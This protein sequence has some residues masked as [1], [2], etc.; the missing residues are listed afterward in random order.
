M[1]MPMWPSPLQTMKMTIVI[2]TGTV[3]LSEKNADVVFCQ[4]PGLLHEPSSGGMQQPGTAQVQQPRALKGN[5]RGSP[6]PFDIS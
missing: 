5:V 2:V 1:I 4:E 6:C 3:R